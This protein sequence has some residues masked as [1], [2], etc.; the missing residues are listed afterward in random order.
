MPSQ[1]N[2]LDVE[3]KIFDCQLKYIWIVRK[4][5]KIKQNLSPYLFSRVHFTP[6]F[7]IPLPTHSEQYGVLQ[8]VH[9]SSSLAQLLTHFSPDSVF[10]LSL[11]RSLP[12]KY[13]LQHE[14]SMWSSFKEIF[15]YSNMGSSNGMQGNLSFSIWS[16][17]LLL[18]WS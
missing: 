6:S 10:V 13:L 11:S 15:N 2:R 4:K 3:K 14:F 12:G 16:T 17:Y 1:A 18:H 5:N 9:N 8:S 7:Q